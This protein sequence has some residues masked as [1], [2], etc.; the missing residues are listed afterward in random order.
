MK[1]ELP[2]V[3][4]DLEADLNA[5]FASAAQIFA[6][7]A[8]AQAEAWE[9]VMPGC[10]QVA[11]LEVPPLPKATDKDSLVSQ[12]WSTVMRGGANGA[13]KGSDGDDENA[14]AG[15]APGEG[16]SVVAASE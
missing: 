15:A 8:A 4:A 3:H 16:Q 10:S 9:N 1:T 12:A 7:L 13:A 5:A 6:N 2:R 14:D 11:P